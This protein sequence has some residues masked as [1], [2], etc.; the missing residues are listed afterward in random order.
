M[1]YGSLANCESKIFI[2][3]V[4]YFISYIVLMQEDGFCPREYIYLAYFFA[5]C[6]L[7]SLF[8]LSKINCIKIE[9]DTFTFV[10]N[11]QCTQIYI[12]TQWI[13]SHFIIIFSCLIYFF[14]FNSLTHPFSVHFHIY[15]IFLR[16]SAFTLIAHI[17]LG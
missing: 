5:S 12:Y 15:F 9:R 3:L 10:Y 7:L 8:A 16:Q 6:R 14:S 1:D 2:N 11:A 17:N 4:I 13:S